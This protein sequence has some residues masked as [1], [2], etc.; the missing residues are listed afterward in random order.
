MLHEARLIAF[1]KR[2]CGDAEYNAC[3]VWAGEDDDV[4]DFGKD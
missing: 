1:T 2:H 4:V 3:P